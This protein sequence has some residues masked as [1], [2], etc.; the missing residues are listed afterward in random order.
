[1]RFKILG[2]TFIPYSFL[3]W[4]PAA[5]STCASILGVAA[6]GVPLPRAHSHNDYEHQRPLLD[7]LDQG[8]NS[9]EADIWLVNGKLLVAHD[10]NQ[11]REER[12][13]E[14]LYLTPLQQRVHSHGGT[15]HPKTGGFMLLIDVKAQPS[16]VWP[17]LKQSLSVYKSMLT[18]FTDTSTVTGAVTVVLSGA[19]PIEQVQAEPVRYCGIDGRLSDLAT[20]PS[21][22]LYPLVSESWRP[23][24]GGFTDGKLLE[25]DRIKLQNLVQQA[26]Q[27]GRRIR[28]WAVPDQ[29]YAWD[30]LFNAKVD[31]I[32]TDKLAELASFL[33]AKADSPGKTKP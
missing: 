29:S 18:Q 24:F 3:R 9:V 20:N 7:A 11:V 30:E 16:E 8:F 32:N 27:Q 15:V 22:H 33:R 2:H 28:F 23:T 31:L 6:E 10:R 12:T 21:K 5:I 4:L 14:S 26:H 1:M 25:S 13:L 19:R 17:V